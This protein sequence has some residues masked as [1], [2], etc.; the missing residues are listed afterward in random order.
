MYLDK[1]K[2]FMFIYFIDVSLNVYVYIFHLCGSWFWPIF[3]FEKNK[4]LVIF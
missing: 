1:I 2:C 4:H 3:L